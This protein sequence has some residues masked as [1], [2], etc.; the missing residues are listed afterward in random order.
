M[1][2]FLLCFMLYACTDTVLENPPACFVC[3]HMGK[4]EPICDQRQD[5][6]CCN[7]EGVS[8]GPYTYCFTD[9][10][11]VL[12]PGD[13]VLVRCIATDGYDCFL[14]RGVI[15]ECKEKGATCQ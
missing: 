8:V 15:V 11:P 7:V 6:C 5:R 2:L 14:N 9:T 3:A 1:K 4:T 10:C 12:S 13:T